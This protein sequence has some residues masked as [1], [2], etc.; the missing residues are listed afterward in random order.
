MSYQRVQLS[1]GAHVGAPAALPADLVGLDDGSLANL[2]AA[3]DPA[4]LEQ[5][6]YADTGFLPVADPPAPTP[7]LLSDYDFLLLFTSDERIAI[8][9]AAQSNG[10]LYVWLD[11]L[12]RVNE[13]HLDDPK[14]IGGIDALVTAGLLTADRAALILAGTPPA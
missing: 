11:L 5:L 2:P 14:T 12:I 7:T 3:L 10:A 9:A 4:A 6:G 8:R 1:T 13:V